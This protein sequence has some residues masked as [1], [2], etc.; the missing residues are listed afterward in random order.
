MNVPKVCLE[1]VL[2]S[3]VL[4]KARKEGYFSSKYEY[5]LTPEFIEVI[6]AFTIC[7]HIEESRRNGTR[8]EESMNIGEIEKALALIMFDSMD[9][10]TEDALKR[11]RNALIK[12]F[13]PDN[14]ESNETYSQKINAA[15]DLLRS[16]IK[17]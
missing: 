8:H 12:A 9:E 3:G 6:R 13:H 7:A 17:Q 11:Q 4:L 15:F 5:S 10:V 2:D 16:T 14:N 1:E